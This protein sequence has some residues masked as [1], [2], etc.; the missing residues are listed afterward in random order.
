MSAIQ[1]IQRNWTRRELKQAQQEFY[2]LSLPIIK[3][4]AHLEIFRPIALIKHED[5]TLE[6]VNGKL[7]STIQMIWESYVKMLQEL[8]D[9]IFGTDP[10][11]LRDE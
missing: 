11:Q 1:P 2:D 8:K 3:E 10:I 6:P 9:S 5:G 4:L 7:P